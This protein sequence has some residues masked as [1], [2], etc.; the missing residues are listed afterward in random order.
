ML[1]ESKTTMAESKGWLYTVPI[2]NYICGA[3]EY[4]FK[5]MHGISHKL[6]DCPACNTPELER[7][8]SNF[9]NIKKTE[10]NKAGDLVKEKIEEFKS[11][12]KEEKKKLA[13]EE[14]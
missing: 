14:L 8:P 4:S 13:S 10:T 7:V 5:A 1:S 9:T 3:C 2:Y 12:L 6:V 11:D